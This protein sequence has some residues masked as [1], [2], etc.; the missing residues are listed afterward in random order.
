MK[1]RLFFWMSCLLFT[2]QS[3]ALH[4]KDKKLFKVPVRIHVAASTTTP[5]L[6]AVISKD[7]LN[8]VISDVNLIWQ[9][10][11]IEFYVE[12][13]LK[14][15]PQNE[16]LYIKTSDKNADFSV[17]AHNK[18]MRKVCKLT[19]WSNAVLNLCIVNQMSD[20]RGG[21][22]YIFKKRSPMVIWP[23]MLKQEVNHNPA[24]LAHE[25]GHALGLPHNT[26]NDIYL[27]RGDGNNMR[28]RGKI[29]RIK[30]TN[31]EVKTARKIAK[32]LMKH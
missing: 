9:K 23:L 14:H 1:V 17:K 3:S 15:A 4:L 18:A 25:F 20:A 24:T 7:E 27:M 21:L 28:R 29:H 16:K 26:Q 31:D 22:T 8:K 12:S 11:K 10:A 2:A 32:R 30:L 19:P 5:A 6:N 13:V